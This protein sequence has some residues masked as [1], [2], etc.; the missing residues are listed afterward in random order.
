MTAAAW[1]WHMVDDRPPVIDVIVRSGAH[2]RPGLRV[3]RVRAL[4]PAD[5]RRRAGLPVTAPARTLVDL[6]GVLE[7]ARLD[8]AF[9]R[10]RTSRLLR[11]ADVRE[12][13]GR[14]PGR[15][16]A[17]A[18][19]AL[20]DDRPGLTRSAAERRLLDLLA[21]GGLPRPMT[22]IRVSGHEV[23][24]LWREA[25]LVVEVDG[26]AWHRGRRSFEHDRRRDADLQVA[27]F[28]VLRFT[29]RRIRD[30]PE[31]VL[32]TLARALQS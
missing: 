23:D 7:T 32:V 24:M 6:A 19:R 9:E 11:P 27:G 14:S 15:R 16:G 3:H 26:Y 8:A 10:A 18:V 5:V 29:W 31:A 25:R 22:N 17:P 28:R 13:L 21:R 20:V 30:E 1:L 12:A 2:S 4:D